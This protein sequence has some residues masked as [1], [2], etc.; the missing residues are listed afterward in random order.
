MPLP[1]AFIW[2]QTRLRP[3]NPKP[4]KP[5]LLD[6]GVPN[7]RCP[8]GI[9]RYCSASE[10][11]EVTERKPVKPNKMGW[12]PPAAVIITLGQDYAAAVKANGGLSRDLASSRSSAA[13]NA[14]I[15]NLP[16]A[17]H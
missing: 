8:A 5:L 14:R 11:A 17:Q 1:P 10:Y 7:P 6:T 16:R 9:C 15:K 13:T 4:P 12:T 2:P 3:L